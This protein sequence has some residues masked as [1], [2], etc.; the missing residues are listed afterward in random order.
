[1]DKPDVQRSAAMAISVVLQRIDI[2]KDAAI[3]KQAELM[4][5]D[6][7]N[8]DDQNVQAVFTLAMLYHGQDYIDQAAKMYERTLALDPAQ[9]IAAN[10]LRGSVPAPE[11]SG[12]GAG[13]WPLKSCR[14]SRITQTWWIHAGS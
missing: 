1:M 6:L 7:L 11:K 13:N 10:Y 5:N 2:K 3:A 12:K 14:L 4:L 9:A 8:K